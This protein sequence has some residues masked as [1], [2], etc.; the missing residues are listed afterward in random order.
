MAA[1]MA[2]H[3]PKT[4]LMHS[5]S[6]LKDLNSSFI[7]GSPLKGLS[8]QNQPRRSSGRH[9]FSLVITSAVTGSSRSGPKT[10]KNS[11]GDNGGGGRFYLNFTGFPFPLGPFLNR[12]TI[13]TEVVKDCIWLFEQEQALGFSSVSTNIRMTVIKL[14][15]GGLWIH[16]P[17]APTKECI[18]MTLNRKFLALAEVGVPECISKESLLASAKNG[19]AVKLLSKGKEVPEEPVVDNQMNRQKDGRGW[20]SRILFLGPSN[21]L[22]PNASFAQMSQKLIVSPIVKTLVFSKVPEKVRDWIDGIRRFAFLDDAPRRA[23]CETRPSLSLKSSHQLLGKAASYFP[24]DDMRTLSSLDELLGLSWSKLVKAIN[25]TA[26]KEQY[27]NNS[28]TE[29]FKLAYGHISSCLKQMLLGSQ[30]KHWEPDSSL[31]KASFCWGSCPLENAVT[32][33]STKIASTIVWIVTQISRAAELQHRSLPALFSGQLTSAALLGHRNSSPFT[34]NFC[35]VI[36][37]NFLSKHGF[38][39]TSYIHLALSLQLQVD[40]ANEFR[41]AILEFSSTVK[42]ITPALPV[43]SQDS[44]YQSAHQEFTQFY[45]QLVYSLVETIQSPGDLSDLWMLY[46]CHYFAAASSTRSIA[47]IGEKGVSTLSIF[48]TTTSS[49]ENTVEYHNKQCLQVHQNLCQLVKELGYPVEYIVLPTFAYE[50]K[51]FVGPFSRKFPRAQVWVAPRQWSWPL[52]LPLEFFGIFRAKTLQDEDLSTPWADDIEQKVLSSPE[53][54]IGPYVEV[55]FYHKR[56]QTLLVTDAVIF[57]P[58]SPPECISKESLLASAKNGLAVKLLSKGKEVPEEPVVDNQMNRQKGWERMVLQILF[59]GPSNLLEPNASFAQMSQKLIVS[60]IVKTLVFSKVPEKVRDWIDG[61]VRDWKFKRIIPAHFAAPINAN[62]SD[63]LAAFAF[64]DDLL[65]ERYVTR[66]S[67][68]L[69][70]TSLLGKAASYFPPDDMRTLSS[71]DDFLVSVGA[72]KKTV[73]GRKR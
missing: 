29:W 28:F 58:R 7:C 9:G 22:E 14:K 4:A 42:I 52:N 65:G 56:S 43:V 34:D 17:I 1:A 72:V 64:L 48:Y 32:S 37:S 30:Q 68:S 50:H 59:L 31:L 46:L 38:F 70:F 16:A 11:G 57:V 24:P 3:S 21:L 26:F 66:P 63:L 39:Q 53:V 25:K 55:A 61:I 47:A 60:P 44:P 15:S 51:I 2:V 62:R 6:S 10:V 8:L 71:L 27:K 19:L 54:G 67:L 35:N 18:Q 12:R 49:L 40:A 41:L 36:S 33:V 5:P 73:S 13:R 23:L 69:I 45:I 20:F